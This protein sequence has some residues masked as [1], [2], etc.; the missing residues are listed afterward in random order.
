M[1]ARAAL[2]VTA[3]IEDV[4][5]QLAQVRA[6][7]ERL[8]GEIEHEETRPVSVETVE[9]RVD[10]TILRLESFAARMLTGGEFIH[11]GGPSQS[12]DH[13]AQLPVH[14]FVL[15]AILNPSQLRVWLLGSAHAALETLPEPVDDATRASRVRELQTKLRT[16]EAAEVELSWAAEAAGIDPNWSGDLD[17]ALVLGLENAA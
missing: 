15:A 12:G 11:L 5:S 8:R 2:K 1:S 4:H 6:E 10:E 9:R 16:V 17:P 7:A 14:P 13:L 3:A